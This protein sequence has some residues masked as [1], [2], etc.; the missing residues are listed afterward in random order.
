MM[1]RAF[2]WLFARFDGND[3]HFYIGMAM[4]FA[5]LYLTAGIGLALIVCGAALASVGFIS[6]LISIILPTLAQKGKR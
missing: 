5:G 3:V 4:L 2:G 1:K 6:V